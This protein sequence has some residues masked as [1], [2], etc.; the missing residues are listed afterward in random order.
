MISARHPIFQIFLGYA[1]VTGFMFSPAQAAD[2]VVGVNVVNPMRASVADQNAIIGELKAA[3][4]R[5]IRAPLTPSYKGIDF[6]KRVYAR[7]IKIELQVGFQYAPNAPTRP[8]Q[9]KEFPDMWGGHPLSSAD[10]G[11]SRAYFQSFIAKLEANG[12]VLA[13]LELGNEIN[14]T[15][16]NPEF[17]LPGKG[18]NFGLYDLYHDPEGQRIARGFL[19]YLKILAVLKEV[20][21]HSKLNQHTPLTGRACR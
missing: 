9:P 20:R 10:P 4:V 12:I 3:G 14:W 21:D 8:Y 19:Q 15:A 18:K 13:G 16:F 7:G 17:P 1:L 6:A 2:F 11:L 5:V